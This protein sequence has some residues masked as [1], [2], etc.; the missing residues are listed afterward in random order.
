M[1]RNIR[2]KSR[3]QRMCN[4]CEIQ[5]K[6]LY[7]RGKL[8]LEIYR[9]VC[10]RTV[11]TARVV[12]ED[13]IDYTAGERVSSDLDSALIYLETF[14]PEEG[15][16]RF[17]EK[18]RSLFEVKWM[19]DVIDAAM[20]KVKEFPVYGDM[21]FDLISAYY[22]GRFVYTESEILELLGVERSTF[23]RRKKEAIT[24]F[25]LCLFGMSK[26]EL[27][28]AVESV[29]PERQISFFDYAAGWE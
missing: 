18:I 23:Y 7:D 21:Y 22:M 24:L 25:G 9:D 14:A 15:K 12:R 1:G 8:L 13:L 29:K 6:D 10:W 3:I 28:H 5:E 17:E 2:T 4:V 27:K 19:I 16:E 26:D 20:V 11:S